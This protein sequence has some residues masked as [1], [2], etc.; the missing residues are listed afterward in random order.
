M[1]KSNRTAPPNRTVPSRRN[2]KEFNRTACR[3]IVLFFFFFFGGGGY[4]PSIWG[5]KIGHLFWLCMNSSLVRSTLWSFPFLPHFFHI[6]RNAPCGKAPSSEIPKI[7]MFIEKWWSS[8]IFAPIISC[9]FINPTTGLV[10][11]I[12][13]QYNAFFPRFSVVVGKNRRLTY[14]RS[15]ALLYHLFHSSCDHP[16]SPRQDRNTIIC[17][18]RGRIQSIVR[19][20]GLL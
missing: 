16:G 20:V 1:K 17:I 19:S 11:T 15:F 12:L 2:A 3:S 13:S 6:S 10:Q 5:T 8:T 14:L 7:A 18:S 9:T 4:L